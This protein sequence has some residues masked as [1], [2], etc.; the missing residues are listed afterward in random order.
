MITDFMQVNKQSKTP[1]YRQIF[2][3]IS[4]SIE[5]GGLTKGT[6]LPS[7][8]KMSEELKISKTTVENAYNQLCAGGYVKNFPKRGYYVEADSAIIGSSSAYIKKYEPYV[9]AEIY[10]YDFSTKNV[11][12]DSSLAEWKKEVKSVLNKEYLLKS[13]GDP[14]GERTLRN[15]LQQYAFAVRGVHCSAD[16]IVIAAG[17]QSLLYLLCGIIGVNKKVLLEK[18]AFIQAEQ[19][20]CDFGYEVIY[21][22]SDEDGINP[23]HIERFNPDIVLINPNFNSINGLGTSINRRLELIKKCRQTGTLIF[24]DDYNG[25]LMYNTIPQRCIQSYDAENTVYIGSFSKIILPSVRIGYM[26][27]PE[28]LLAEYRKRM[29]NYNQTSSKTEQLALSEFIAKGLMEKRLRKLRRIYAEKSKATV[30]ALNSVFK[31][32]ISLIFSET[33]LSVFIKHKDPINSKKLF[34]LCEEE[35]IR[36]NPCKDEK[37]DYILSFAGIPQ[38]LI[39]DGISKLKTVTDKAK[40]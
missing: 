26:V 21:C 9:S 14:Q 7:I 6:K 13:Y 25:E 20:F 37:F 1:I 28:K 15:A 3:N 12:R 11:E 4:K 8:R 10:K 22:E 30:N 2:D 5:S 38:E 29:A 19:I 18:G 34:E 27:L 32:D 24:E 36:I 31:D 39:Y 16:N 40:N 33:S 23:E 17:T 35:R